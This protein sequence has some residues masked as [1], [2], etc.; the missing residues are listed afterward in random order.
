MEPTASRCNDLFCDDFVTLSRSHV[1]SCSRQLCR[2]IG[3]LRLGFF[4]WFLPAMFAAIVIQILRT[5]FYLS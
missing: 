1:R 4:G 5:V 3:L 2:R